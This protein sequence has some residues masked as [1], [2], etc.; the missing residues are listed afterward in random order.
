M[1]AQR[2]T[3]LG[4]PQI[5]GKHALFQPPVDDSESAAQKALPQKNLKKSSKNQ[6]PQVAPS[7]RVRTTID[8]TGE[9]LQ[10]I[11]QVQQEHRLRTGK[12]LPLW[13]AVSQA[14]T[15]YGERQRK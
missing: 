3:G 10:I 2:L 15:A 14:I 4:K 8:L 6:N 9:A 7:R 12:V 13:K 11:Q 5:V 1:N